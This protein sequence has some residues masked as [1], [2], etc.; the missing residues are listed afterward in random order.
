MN[1]LEASDLAVR[2]L[3]NNKNRTDLDRAGRAYSR[4]WARTQRWQQKIFYMLRDIY[5]DASDEELVRVSKTLAALLKSADRNKPF[6]ISPLAGLRLLAAIVPK[7]FKQRSQLVA[8][9]KS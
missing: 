8:I 2:Q 9:L 7:V 1:T 5:F 6:K 3:L 4:G